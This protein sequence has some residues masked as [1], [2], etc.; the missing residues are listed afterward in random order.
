MVGLGEAVRRWEGGGCSR[1]AVAALDPIATGAA[2]QH[3]DSVPP[4]GVA[5]E[6]RGKEWARGR[7]QDRLPAGIAAAGIAWYAADSL[8]HRREG[9]HGYEL[10]GEVD[11]SG[12]SFLRA[13]EALTGAPVSYGNDA[14]LLINGDRIFPAYLGA[15]LG[16]EETVNMLTY[17]YWR[18]DI[19]IEVADALREKAHAGV[20][21]N[22]IVD[23]VGAARM[24][25]KLVRH[26]RDAGAADRLVRRRAHA[27]A[28]PR[29]R[30]A[31]PRRR[32]AR[33]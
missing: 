22:L 4:H 23:A 17:A 32:A 14:D 5:P 26:M 6:R 13:A 29:P 25:R 27:P 12:P 3:L 30:D 24:D 9:G 2:A 11:V 8:R 7:G 10:R 31:R 21:C 16:A 18:G 20:E 33:W 1:E 19:A 15:I 28:A